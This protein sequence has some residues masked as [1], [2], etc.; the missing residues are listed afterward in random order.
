MKDLKL[1]NPLHLYLLGTVLRR[2][3]RFS[4]Y[5]HLTESASDTS[6]RA[7][8]AASLFEVGRPKDA[9]VCF[10]A[11]EHWSCASTMAECHL[12]L[13]DRCEANRAIEKVGVKDGKGYMA[14]R[15]S[16]ATFWDGDVSLA[17]ELWPHP[18]PDSTLLM[19]QGRFPECWEAWSREIEGSVMA[20]SAKSLTLLYFRAILWMYEERWGEALQHFEKVLSC[21]EQDPKRRDYSSLY[22]LTCRC[23]M[24][25]ARLEELEELS[26]AL[27][28]RYSQAP[29]IQLDIMINRADVMSG[30]DRHEQV[31][32]L[33]QATLLEEPRAFYRAF[34]MDLR[35]SALRSLGQIAEAE[36][37]DQAILQ[38]CP[39]SYWAKRAV[40]RLQL[41][42]E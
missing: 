13:L 12:F 41:P 25:E 2:E 11:E 26:K 6:V 20:P 5:L 32:E 36:E 8:R 4:E 28:A 19:Y 33:V 23:W 42:P 18:H 7:Q 31:L 22:S 1:D 10:P 37:E 17:Q 29:L 14:W 15:A 9:L 24:G 27:S 38:T 40:L 39:G 30:I 3:R 35:S 34:L 21:S 16:K